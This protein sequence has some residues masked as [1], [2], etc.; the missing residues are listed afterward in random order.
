MLEVLTLIE[1]RF[2]LGES[3]IDLVAVHLDGNSFSSRIAEM[4]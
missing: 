1:E 4:A 3:K 2:G